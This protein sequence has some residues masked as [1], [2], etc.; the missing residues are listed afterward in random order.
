MQSYTKRSFPLPCM[1][2][3]GENCPLLGPR[4]NN[5]LVIVH[6]NVHGFDENEEQRV[7]W[8]VAKQQQPKPLLRHPSHNHNFEYNVVEEPREDTNP[9]SPRLRCRRLDR[10]DICIR[11]TSSN[12]GGAAAAQ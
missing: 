9:T 3:V 4:R 1:V 11:S 12:G 6:Q 7:A 8:R 10:E 2:R 5:S